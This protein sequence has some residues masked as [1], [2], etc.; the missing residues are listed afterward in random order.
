MSTLQQ[1]LLKRY[2]SLFGDKTYRQIAHDSGIQLSRV[3]RI[4]NG[5]EMKI[6]EYQSLL[7]Q[8]NGK[9]R[10]QVRVI[11][12]TLQ[13]MTQLSQKGQVELERL[14]QRRVYLSQLQYQAGSSL[15][16]SS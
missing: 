7:E 16:A 14:L 15:V 6:G 3:Y 11:S 5:S 13:C 12:L 9:S 4:F 8:M 1:S 10:D 2:H